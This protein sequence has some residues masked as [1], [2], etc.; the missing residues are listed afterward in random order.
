MPK[1]LKFT[2]VILADTVVKGDRRKY[3]IVNTFAGDVIV[4][5]FPVSLRFGLYAEFWPDREDDYDLTLEIKLDRKVYAK[6]VVHITETK[7]GN[8]AVIALPQF[9]LGLEKE[10]TLKLDVAADGYRKKQILSK[11][12]FAGDVT[13]S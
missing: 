2:N 6:A 8:P 10:A 4:K 11:K 1:T 12:I 9:E 5:E 7:L 13:G 3:V